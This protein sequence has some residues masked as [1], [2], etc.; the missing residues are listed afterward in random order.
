MLQSKQNKYKLSIRYKEQS[1]KQLTIARII[2]LYLIRCFQKKRGLD[3]RFN[4]IFLNIVKINM[5][6][7]LKIAYCFITQFNAYFTINELLYILESSEHII[8]RYIACN[9]NLRF[10][11]R[12]YFFYDEEQ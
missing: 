8:R 2:N 1:R 3:Y 10:C 4:N 9:A 12:I 5:S 7:D 11:P 6:K